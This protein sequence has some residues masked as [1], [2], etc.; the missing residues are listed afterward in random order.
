M[1]E[2]P[3][4][5]LREARVVI[6]QVVRGIHW[7]QQRAVAAVDAGTAQ[8]QVGLVLHRMGPRAVT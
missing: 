4:Q 7:S 1:R 3:A 8:G 5:V 6:R 2:V